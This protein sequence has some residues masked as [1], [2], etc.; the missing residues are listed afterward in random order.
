MARPALTEDA[1]PNEREEREKIRHAET[2]LR[3]LYG[4][5]AAFIDQVHQFSDA[6]KELFD[7]RQRRQ[8]AVEDQYRTHQ[9]LGARLG[10][11]RRA[12]DA[13]RSKL[14]EAV[15]QG[16]LLRSQLPRGT[17]RATPEQIRREME[18]LEH[19][20]QTTAMPVKDENALIDRLRALKADL[21]VADRD[22]A[23]VETAVASRKAS[24][25]AVR[26]RKAELDKVQMEFEH[27]RSERERAMA[28]IRTRLV[29]VGGLLATLREKAKARSEAM[30]RVD[31]ISDEIRSIERDV[32]SRLR[33]VRD[34]RTEARRTIVNYNREVRENVAGERAYAQAAEAQLDELMKRGKVTLRG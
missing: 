23:V 15:V 2:K 30:A 4:R 21:V 10:E 18:M 25:E 28:S 20:Q 29:D 16:R 12:R 27:V 34:R 22:R 26:A 5:R 32:N 7:E 8:A 33:A 31:A 9:D 1:E 11:L 3:D 13:A 19:R 14:D 6:Q 24:E 17:D